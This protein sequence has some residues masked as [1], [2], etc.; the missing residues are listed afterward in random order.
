MKYVIKGLILI[1][2]LMQANLLVADIFRSQDAN[3]NISFSDKQSDSS[4]RVE[5]AV[6]AYRYKHTVT[7]VYDGDTIVLKNGERVRL[8]GIN[9][10]EIES[11]RRQGEAG[12][13]AA[14]KW[15]QDKLQQNQ[16]FIEYDQLQRD[17]YH[18]LLAYV[19]L[20][21]GKH[22]N[23]GLLTAGLANL[24]VIPPNLRLPWGIEES[25]I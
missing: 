12:G 16:V 11:H 15:L 24:S 14:K 4:I 22:L 19:F 20:P 10:P 17:Q 13:Q 1:G 18:R 21:D 3:G 6:R 23:V 5:P 2:L 9:T 7:K 25:G 8:L